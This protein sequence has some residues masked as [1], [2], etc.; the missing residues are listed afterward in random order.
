MSNVAF[1]HRGGERMASYRY[2]TMIPAQQL[3]DDYTVSINEG[4]ADIV[5][6]SKPVEEDI[7]IAETCRS[8]GTKVVVDY[9]DDHFSHKSLGE[10][11][12]KMA[13]L[14]DVIVCNT[15]AMQDVIFE[16]TGKDSETIGDPYEQER[17]EPH[18]DG[19]N[20]LWFG[21]ARNIHEI[22]PWVDKVENL[23]VCTGQNSQLT[24]YVPWSPDNLRTELEYANTVLLPGT[25]KYKSPN[26]LVNS[27]M[28]G[29]FV[30]SSRHPA[31]KE[32]REFVWVGK[33]PA[34]LQWREYFH[35][36]LNS[37]VSAGQ[38]YIESKYSPTEIGKQ[39][40]SLLAG[41]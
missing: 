16:E 24:G 34:G 20:V 14:A 37:L 7:E 28:A 17:A 6:F 5:V 30:V 31:N 18:A 8:D 26:R 25:V 40:K 11:Y 41:L 2:R 10:I 12:K 33:I 9:C 4:T 38:D 23:A 22:V 32:F 1:I 29:C 13:D 27:I 36:D 19:P 15:P 21:H 3:S 35:E 39:W